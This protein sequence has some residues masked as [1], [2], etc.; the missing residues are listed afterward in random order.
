MGGF[1]FYKM[2]GCQDSP[3]GGFV[4][5][6]EPKKGTPESAGGFSLKYPCGG[7]TTSSGTPT[8]V[9]R[10]VEAPGPSID[11]T[12]GQALNTVFLILVALCC[13]SP[14]FCFVCWMISSVELDS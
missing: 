4:D 3:C 2:A 12:Y 9:L 13:C 7:P 1:S 14:C 5:P 8:T 10:F 6:N 11:G